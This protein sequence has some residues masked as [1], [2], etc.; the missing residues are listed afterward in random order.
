[1]KVTKIT[2]VLVPIL[3]ISGCTLGVSNAP[4]GYGVMTLSIM[5][6]FALPFV[7]FADEKADKKKNPEKYRL[8]A[9]KLQAEKDRLRAE[10]EVRRAET[11]RK[12][13][14]RR[15][16]NSIVE[17]KIIGGGSTKN[18]THGLGGA[19][20]GGALFGVPGA[21][22]GSVIPKGTEQMVRFAVKY[23][24]GKVVIKECHPNSWEYKELMKHVKWEDLK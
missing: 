21:I 9:E 4:F 14:R 10:R 16:E 2:A 12:E 5:L 17:V 13:E 7:A 6:L 20:V 23:G 24:S 19:I 8:K 15:Y 1:M 18:K 3:F 11:H 22:V